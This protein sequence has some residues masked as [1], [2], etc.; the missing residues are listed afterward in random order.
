ME[1]LRILHGEDTNMEKLRILIGLTEIAGYGANL[2]KG[3][4]Q[5]GIKCDFIS[6]PSHPFEY[7]GEDINLLVRGLD[8]LHIKWVGTPQSQRL[9]KALLFVLYGLARLI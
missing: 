1:K 7:G 9:I 6:I 3:F 4:R 2:R 8:W 5:L